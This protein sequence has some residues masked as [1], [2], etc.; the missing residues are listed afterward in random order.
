METMTTP[1]QIASMNELCEKL[2][3]SMIGSRFLF[4]SAIVNDW[5]RFGNFDIHVVPMIHD[6]TS[7]N[8]IKAA[9]NKL[10][11]AG[12]KLREIFGP[13]TIR[14]YDSYNR[15]YRKTGYSRDY[16]A[17]DIDFQEYHSGLNRFSS[18]LNGVKVDG[19][20]VGA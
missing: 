14:E 3:N 7:T 5:G 12:C 18:Q 13:D 20:P 17:I 9:V 6:R 11:P 8:R 15:R 1:E 16:W 4:R 10:L 2:K 19:Y